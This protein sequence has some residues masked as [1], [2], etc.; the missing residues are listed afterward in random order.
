MKNNLAIFSPAL[1]AV[2]ETFIRRHIVSIAPERTV[3]ITNYKA[4]P[5]KGHWSVECPT[6][7]L[8][9][10]D[11]SQQGLAFF[12]KRISGMSPEIYQDYMIS[13][14]L[15]KHRVDV[16]M[17][18]YLDRSLKL[19][20]IAKKLDIRFFVHAHGYDLS[21]K[22][23][24][25]K[26]RKSYCSYREADGVI[27]VNKIQKERL[28]NLGLDPDKVHI[29]PCGVEIPNAYYPK[30]KSDKV[31]CVAVG[32]MVAKKA[33]IT[34]LNAFRQVLQ[35][36]PGVTLEYVGDGP[37]MP[38]VRQFVSEFDLEGNIILH[39]SLPNQVT[40]TIMER[41][42]IFLQHSVTDPESGDEEG[43]PVAILEA[44]ARGLPVVSTYHAGIPEAVVD[45][46]TGFLVAEEDIQ[47][48]AAV[49]ERLIENPGLRLELGTKGRER[50]KDFFSSQ[51]EI[52]TLR[53][54][55]KIK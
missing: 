13:K 54:I 42:D 51:K 48:M 21:L 7:I 29:V 19:L 20:P 9:K 8:G 47:A 39:G 33:P 16:I 1:G 30:K 3:V 5:V 52:S 2:S 43:L 25:P 6:L 35:K 55:L 15:K 18:E 28:V 34:L 10:P 44:M 17:G 46:E 50:A 27:T 23:R 31:R 45:S 36:Y 11:F 26:I 38:E 49:L 40:M 37:L 24:D 41:S 22:F 32:R 14:F 53:E 12:L 4:A